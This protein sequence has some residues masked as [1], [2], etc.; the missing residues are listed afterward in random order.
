MNP[1]NIQ[2][3]GPFSAATLKFKPASLSVGGEQGVQ[4]GSS[5]ELAVTQKSAE[6]WA[7]RIK[8]AH[9]A[10][11]TD[12]I[13]LGRLYYGAKCELRYGEWSRM[14]RLPKARRLPRSKRS[15]DKYALV[16]QEF[17]PTDEQWAA[18]FEDKLPG[19]LKALYCLAELGRQLVLELILDGTVDERLSAA[20]AKEL[21]HQYRPEL[22][23]VR[24]FNMGG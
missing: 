3:I 9:Q 14:W 18:H 7:A 4:P 23:K 20:K 1:T 22:K 6:E 16:G 8:P 2:T 17:G 10:E 15:G 24:P 12:I 5:D 19:T 11:K 21:L 13:A